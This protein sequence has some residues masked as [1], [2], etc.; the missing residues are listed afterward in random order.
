MMR[1]GAQN[2]ATGLRT[3]AE[4]QQSKMQCNAIELTEMKAKEI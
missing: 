2:K 1:K 4:R 3:I